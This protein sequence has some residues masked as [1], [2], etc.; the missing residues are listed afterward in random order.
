MRLTVGRR[1]GLTFA[2]VLLVVAALGVYGFVSNQLAAARLGETVPAAMDCALAAGEMELY[3]RGAAQVL[4]GQ[5]AAGTSDLAPIAA[6]RD[7]F[8]PR[9]SAVSSERPRP[10]R[11]PRR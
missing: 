5:A 11:R 8:S 6:A 9:R 4:S 7:G 10:R 2:S 3:A 1:V